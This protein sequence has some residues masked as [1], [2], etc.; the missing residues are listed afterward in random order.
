MIRLGK[1]SAALFLSILGVACSSAGPSESYAGSG[2]GPGSGAWNDANISCKTDRDCAT[3]EACTNGICELARCVQAYTSQAPMGATHY[4]GLEGELAIVADQAYVDAFQSSNGTPM[5][6]WDLSGKQALD[7]VGGNFDG[8]QE[9]AAAI[10]HT[11]KV[12]IRNQQGQ[13][14]FDVGIMP[15]FLG[16][17]DVDADGTDELVAFGT[18]GSVSVCHIS[19]KKCS[20]TSIDAILGSKDAVFGE[21]VTVADV[22]G[23]GY[24]E[25]VFLY[26][27]GSTQSILVWN[28]NAAQTSQKTYVK[29]SPSEQLIAIAAGDIDGSATADIVGLEPGYVDPQGYSTSARLHVFSGDGKEVGTAFDV[30]PAAV[31][32]AAGDTNSDGQAEVA[33]LSDDT[34]LTNTRTIDLYEMGKSGFTGLNTMDVRSGTTASRIAIADWNNSSASARLVSG[35]KLVAGQSVPIAVYLFP[36]YNR[37]FSDGVSSL[38]MGNT[39]VNDKSYSDTVSLHLG[40]AVS[41]GLKA[42]IFTAKVGGYF[43]KDYTVTHSTSSTLVVGTRDAVSAD[44]ARYGQNYGVVEMANG[45]YH[46]YTYVTNDP[47][48]LIGGSG[49]KVNVFVPVGGQTLLMSST[50]YNAMVKA[51]NN[52]LPTVHIASSVGDPA[53]YPSST[54]TLDG[55]P[56]SGEDLLFPKPPTFQI[57]DVATMGFWLTT[58]KTTTNGAAETTTVGMNAGFGALGAE[59]DTDVN[60][61]T[62]QGYS[63]S[64][65]NEAVFAGWAPPIPDNPSTPEDEYMQHRYTFMPYVYR[66]HWGNSGYYVLDYAVGH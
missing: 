22:D 31:D 48:N 7:I 24:A 53:S 26:K 52:G 1:W 19:Q 15:S 41:F 14:E 33:V 4:F 34:T 13:T 43:N 60:T 29:W 8:Q 61:G 35:P 5:K 36:P 10:D 37:Q 21:D 16:A 62:T 11:S 28:T 65:G 17:G 45:C 39:K 9:V 32:V 40:L 30:N 3:G 58:V 57:S 50:R 23:D 51:L 59:I 27:S 49:Q 18:D 46:E 55:Q 56:V 6:T 44:P 38:M 54:V 66:A 47:A 63:I 64:V 2:G 12:L 20:I 42:S 25:P